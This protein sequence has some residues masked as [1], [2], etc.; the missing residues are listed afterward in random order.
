MKYRGWDIE[1]LTPDQRPM[2][3][4]E[5]QYI[6]M[7]HP[8]AMDRR[9]PKT[10]PHYVKTTEEA[11]QLIDELEG[12]VEENGGYY[13]E[14]TNMVQGEIL[15]LG[16]R[17]GSIG[18]AVSHAKKFLQKDFQVYGDDHLVI[19]IFDKS[20]DERIGITYTPEHT[21]SYWVSEPT[22]HDFPQT[23]SDW[24]HLAS[25]IH[26]R[27]PDDPATRASVNFSLQQIAEGMEESTEAQEEREQ[28]AQ[29]GKRWL[30]SKAA[31]LGIT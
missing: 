8:M 30:T 12:T 15:Q 14:V 31:E 5:Y 3:L 20:P 9:D 13:W 26:A 10:V 27:Y 18:E 2:Y 21:E 29:E 25:D 6:I 24:A 23:Y 17:F 19:K 7:K 11:K 16:T 28:A 22:R 4:G 1:Y